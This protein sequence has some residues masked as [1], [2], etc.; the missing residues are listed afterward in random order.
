MSRKPSPDLGRG[1]IETY[2]DQPRMTEEL[3]DD[4]RQ[5]PEPDPLTGLER[6]RQSAILSARA[7]IARS[8]R[9]CVKP[10]HVV[11]RE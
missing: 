6:R 1:M 9:D 8:E 4:C 3:F 2:G 7:V 11:D 10:Q 5:R